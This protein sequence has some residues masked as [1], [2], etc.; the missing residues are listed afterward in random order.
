MTFHWGERACISGYSVG[1]F[2]FGNGTLQVQYKHS[3][4]TVA[5][6]VD[7]ISTIHLGPSHPARICLCR[8]NRLIGMLAESLL[9]NG[10]A[11]TC[12]GISNAWQRGTRQQWKALVRKR[13]DEAEER[14]GGA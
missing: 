14:D 5:I 10:V 11:L 7:R 1:F 13:V 12:F 6:I 2:S 4:V 3:V 8:L 9:N